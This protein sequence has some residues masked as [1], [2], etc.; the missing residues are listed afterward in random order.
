[1]LERNA[2]SVTHNKNGVQ[3]LRCGF[4]TGVLVIMGHFNANKPQHVL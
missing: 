3:S 2:N 4:V 1:M